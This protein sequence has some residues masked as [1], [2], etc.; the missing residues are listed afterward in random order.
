M[1]NFNASD[2]EELLSFVGKAAK[3]LNEL[4]QAAAATEAGQKKFQAR[5]K[6]TSEFIDKLGTAAFS[7]EHNTG[8]YASSVTDVTDGLGGMLQK[9][10]P[11][12]F[13]VGTLTKI[14]GGL[15]AASLKQNDG[16]IKTYRTLSQFG[17]IEL[18]GVDR[19]QE[20]LADIGTTFENVQYFT[21][22][23]GEVAPDLVAFKGSVTAGKDAMV[24][25]T[26]ALLN[27]DL[28]NSL[29]NIGFTTEQI[30]EFSTK[31]TA[32]QAKIGATQG[33][34]T[35]QLTKSAFNYMVVLTE[36]ADL[37]GQSRD[38]LQKQLEEQQRDVSYRAYLNT[39]SKEEKAATEQA[40]LAMG[41]M[42][43]GYGEAAR[44][45]LALRG[46]VR[47]EQGALIQMQ[48]P[49]LFRAMK[50]SIDVGMKGG[51]AALDVVKSLQAAEPGIKKNVDM[52]GQTLMAGGPEA[53]KALGIAD[54]TYNMLERLKN[55]GNLEEF[56][57]QIKKI[58]EDQKGRIALGT[59][60]EQQE[61]QLVNAQQSLIKNIGDYAVPMITKFSEGLNLMGLGLAKFTKVMT[62]GTVDFTDMFRTFDNLNDV[63][64]ALNIEDKKQLE[65]A[66]KLNKNIVSNAENE[67]FI[68]DQE[69]LKAAG[70]KYNESGLQKGYQ[71]R[72]DHVSA[73]AGIQAEINS[74]RKRQMEARSAGAKFGMGSTTPGSSGNESSGQQTP[75]SQL[76]KFNGSDVGRLNLLDPSLKNKLIESAEEFYKETGQPLTINSAYR[77]YQEQAKAYDDFINK[78][79]KFPAAKPGSSMHE[80]GLAVDIQE[81]QNQKALDILRK[82]GLN[83]KIQND[84]VHF[85]QAKTGGLFDGPTS[86]YPVMLHGKESVLP[87]QALD[88]LVSK[89]PLPGTLFG[90]NNNSANSNDLLAAMNGM[91]SML[92]ALND[93]FRRVLGV[94]EDILTHTKMLA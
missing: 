30:F 4:D 61:R 75:L 58:M 74:S 44:E 25:V 77:T 87:T 85:E 73:N 43:K 78:R 83:N 29:K 72:Q 64:E 9:L 39:L 86:G 68:K 14:F 41:A 36:L 84:P 10:G 53:A 90:D 16:L 13:A 3:T 23:L 42:N 20:N 31:F 46:G 93:T 70:K 17:S 38:S 35:E 81:Y 55:M 28:E 66:E 12:G 57:K 2:L 69:A 7:A 27:G 47:S 33:K 65:L 89:L 37:T 8:K 34:S 24:D 5:L 22:T 79:S 82:H 71:Y 45:M 51:D 6:A 60:Q 62:G 56:S 15:A 18:N 49:G 1:A 67:K 52:F 80:S 76:F 40:V 21:Q 11:L 92:D 63:T 19:L 48:F 91:Q 26:H 32:S 50:H 59:K 88:S 54:D 94:Q